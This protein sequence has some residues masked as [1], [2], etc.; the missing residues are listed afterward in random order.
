MLDHWKLR[1]LS[2]IHVLL[3]WYAQ[4]FS[5]S[6][7]IGNLILLSHIEIKYFNQLL[8]VFKLKTKFYVMV[9]LQF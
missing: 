1:E 8:K 2:Q 6:S 5:N 9:Y 4:T 3:L 7:K